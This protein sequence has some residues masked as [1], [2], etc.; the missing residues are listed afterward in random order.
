MQSK[1]VRHMKGKSQ[2]TH[3][4]YS[5]IPKSIDSCSLGDMGLSEPVSILRRGRRKVRLQTSMGLQLRDIQVLCL[6]LMLVIEPFL[7]CAAAAGGVVPR[8]RMATPAAGNESLVILTNC[9]PSVILS[10]SNIPYTCEVNNDEALS[11]LNLSAS[12]YH[13]GD[14]IPGWPATLDEETNTI[15]FMPDHGAPSGRWELVFTGRSDNVGFSTPRTTNKSMDFML[16]EET[17]ADF[18]I[19]CPYYG[20]AVSFAPN[21]PSGTMAS[22]YMLVRSFD[23]CQYTTTTCTDS[24]G[25]Y[26]ML[27]PAHL[28][29]P[30]EYRLCVTSNDWHDQYLP[31]GV[32]S[33]EVK[34][35]LATPLYL[36]AGKDRNVVLQ[37]AESVVSM[38]RRVFLERCPDNNCPRV[39]TGSGEKVVHRDACVNTS[40]SSRVYLSDLRVLSAEAGV[41]AVCVDGDGDGD[42]EHIAPAAL[43]VAVLE[44][45]FAFKITADTDQNTAT[46]NVTGGDLEWRREPYT[47]CAVPQDETCD[48]VSAG[49]RVCEKSESPNSL[50]VF[51]D[52]ASRGMPVQDVKFCFIAANVTIGG[53]TYTHMQD[54]LE[55]VW[56]DVWE[57]DGESTTGMSGGFIA[58]IVIAGA[59]LLSA[60]VVAVVYV[61]HQRRKNRREPPDSGTPPSPTVPHPEQK[62]SNPL[63]TVSVGTSPHTPPPTPVPPQDD[64]AAQVPVAEQPSNTAERHI[65]PTNM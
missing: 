26:R 23:V 14:L 3:L 25:C 46:I 18:A 59:V 49:P 63:T 65:D 30:G 13:K 27:P 58:G 33:L 16:S 50:S 34:V 2:L 15:T 17:N 57:D 56:E 1:N 54:V 31:W 32:E 9:F 7:R 36:T 20:M 41:Y 11:G 64:G 44:K 5:K 10:P 62:K 21:L 40:V 4:R 47:V 45:P 48:S 28:P 35:L 8:T 51:L 38:L 39:T 37:D 19:L 12:Y 29:P 43:P 52:L 53:R 60:L 55:D 42:G 24:V 6:V 61:L 22:D